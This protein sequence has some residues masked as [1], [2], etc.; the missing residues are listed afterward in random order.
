M[1]EQFRKRENS[2]EENLDILANF[3]S[4]DKIQQTLNETYYRF[5][6]TKLD[7]DFIQSYEIL[8]F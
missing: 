5:K 1:R 7:Q 2:E 8:I 6:D 4:I 3:I